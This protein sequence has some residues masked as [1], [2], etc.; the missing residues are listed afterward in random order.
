M[1]ACMYL[2]VDV[3]ICVC[4]CVRVRVCVRAYVFECVWISTSVSIPLS[5]GCKTQVTPTFP[6]SSKKASLDSDSCRKKEGGKK[7]RKEGGKEL[8]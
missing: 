4:V 7:V 2:C 1:F 8:R 6:G 3:Y 5:P